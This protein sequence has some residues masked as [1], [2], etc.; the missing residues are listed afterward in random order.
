MKGKPFL[1]MAFALFFMVSCDNHKQLR[2]SLAFDQNTKQLIFFSD[3]EEYEREVS[4]Y[5]AL[6]ELKRD[7][8]EEIKDMKIFTTSDSKKY[9]ETFQIDRCPALI[10]FY[11]N[12][13]IVV[14]EGKATVEEIVTPVSNALSSI[15]IKKI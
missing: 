15:L 14:I 7:Y 10:V 4:Y 2:S 5:D 6:I 3:E 11:N 13:V 12:E 1:I 8:P 9:F